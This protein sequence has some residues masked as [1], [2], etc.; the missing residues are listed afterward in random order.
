MHDD[1]NSLS[2]KFEIYKITINN[3]HYIGLTKQGI[4]KRLFQHIYSA[5][6]NTD[7]YSKKHTFLS[8]A[9]RKHGIKNIKIELLENVYGVDEALKK[10]EFYINLYDSTNREKGYNILKSG[11]F[12]LNKNKEYYKSESYR[13]KRALAVKGT[14][15]GRYSGVTDE[16]II[17]K[18]LLFFE[19]TGH[20][21]QSYWL[22]YC[23]DNKLPQNYDKASKFR[24]QG[25][26]IHGFYEAFLNK[27]VTNNVTVNF[28]QLIDL[29]S[30]KSSLKNMK[31]IFD[32]FP[33]Y[34]ISD[35]EMKYFD[36]LWP[37]KLNE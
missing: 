4:K 27:C 35:E 6:C 15:N 34:R 23:K 7:K 26:G 19:Q 28:S 8:Y 1:I 30:K 20:I 36:V 29:K 3:K 13:K 11:G 9:I 22:S 17:D 33:K 32:K 2:I 10:E 37:K 16:Q 21:K 18:A 24:F 5:N 31:N 12:N 25:K 14:K